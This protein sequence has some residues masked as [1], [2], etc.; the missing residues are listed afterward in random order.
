MICTLFQAGTAASGRRLSR[1]PA[2]GDIAHGQ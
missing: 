2:N 1:P